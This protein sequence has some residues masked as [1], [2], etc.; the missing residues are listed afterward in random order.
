MGPQY[1]KTVDKNGVN[2]VILMCCSLGVLCRK[3]CILAVPE[4]DNV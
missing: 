2:V 4:N 1:E 3:Q